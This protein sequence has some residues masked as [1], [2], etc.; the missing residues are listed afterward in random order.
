M[1]DGKIFGKGISFPPRIGPDGRVAWSSG[2]QNIKEAIRIILLTEVKERL[3]LPE[4]GGGMKMFLFMPNNIATYRLI[5]DR[6]MRALTMWEP[7][8]TGASVSVE[9]DP[10]DDEAAIITITYRL[11]ATGA[12][13]Q[14]NMTLK[15]KS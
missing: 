15:L 2:V 14:M 7:R 9:K 13:D 8:I 5:Q 11:V 10:A 1:D 6:I 4:F 3:M 12:S